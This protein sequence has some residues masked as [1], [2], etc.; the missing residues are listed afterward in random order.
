MEAKDSR[1]GSY[2]WRSILKG[3]DVIQ[4]GARWRVRDGKSINIWQH[5]WIPRKT[6]SLVVSYP[7]E[8]M[9]NCSVAVLIDESERRWNEEM[10]DGI[11]SQEEA[12][13]IKK[14]PLSR[15]VNEDVPIWP[16]TNDGQYT[17][18]TGYWFL[19]E[20]AKMDFVQVDSGA[21]SSLW[22]GIWSLQIPNRVKNLLWR[23]CRGAMPTKEALVRRTIIDDPLCDRCHEA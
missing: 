15:R 4:R 8:S 13:I 11:F 10:I 5:R 2:A 21:D 18:K 7:I 22:K 6:S 16:Y 19:K 20:E 1:G 3:R 12:A 14:I 9:E 23:A 17:C